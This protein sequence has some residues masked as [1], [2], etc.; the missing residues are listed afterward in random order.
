MGDG[1]EPD[2]VGG[3]DAAYPLVMVVLGDLAEHGVRE[4]GRSLSRLGA[5]QVDGAGDCGMCRDTHRE[6][7]VRA[8]P[9]GVEHLGLDLGEWAIDTGA[10]DRKSTRLNS[11]H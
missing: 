4:T 8:E 11:S 10:Q 9:Q 5:D 7:L 2:R 1:S 6:Q 3:G